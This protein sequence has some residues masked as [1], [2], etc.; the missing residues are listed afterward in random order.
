MRF[1]IQSQGLHVHGPSGEKLA[2][3]NISK[4][5][6]EELENKI[7]QAE[8]ALK[9]IGV[10]VSSPDSLRAVRRVFGQEGVTAFAVAQ[11][12]RVERESSARYNESADAL[13]SFTSA[14]WPLRVS[15]SVTIKGKSALAQAVMAR[16]EEMILDGKGERVDGQ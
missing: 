1:K 8:A 11:R 9:E 6:V 5:I 16:V 3:L 4:E 12:V 13:D 15:L 10:K 7:A 14:S 2:Y